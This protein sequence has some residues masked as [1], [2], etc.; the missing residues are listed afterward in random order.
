MKNDLIPLNVENK[1]DCLKYKDSQNFF[2][3]YSMRKEKDEVSFNK[4]EILSK[5]SF[6]IDPNIKNPIFIKVKDVIKHNNRKKSSLFNLED[7]HI[8]KEENFK[9]PIEERIVNKN[10]LNIFSKNTNKSYHKFELDNDKHLVFN[11]YNDNSL[12]KLS[13]S[14]SEILPNNQHHETLTSNCTSM[15]SF[16][17]NTN[18]PQINQNLN[19]KI[20]F[21]MNTLDFDSK[22]SCPINLAFPHELINPN[23]LSCDNKLITNTKIKVNTKDLEETITMNKKSRLDLFSIDNQININF[24][25]NKSKKLEDKIVVLHNNLELINSQQFQ[26]EKNIK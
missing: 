4:F 12:V 10:L 13:D 9:I 22:D 7:L 15:I 19:S 26:G 5:K 14:K 3:N 21:D 17:N 11:K 20:N 23:Y 1:Y 8:T 2:N 16:I 24:V 6:Q 25:Y 18:I